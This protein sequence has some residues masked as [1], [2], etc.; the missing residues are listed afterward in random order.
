MDTR[1]IYVDTSVLGGCFDAEFAPW[2]KGLVE[3]FRRG[4][5]QPVLS[6]VTAEEISRAPEQ[7]RGLHEEL[8]SLGAE[9]VT[10][11]P[12]ALRL[13]AAYERRGILGARYR[14]D[15]L[16]IAL[17]TVAT[18]DALVSWNFRHIVRMEKIQLFND[19][20]VELGYRALAIHSPREVTTYEQDKTDSSS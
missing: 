12:E 11:S 15:L 13:L 5:F 20:N 1:R 4:V 14:N 6:G 17:A 2:S 9:I 18:V 7:V 8:T 19:V 3:D 10:T 16:H